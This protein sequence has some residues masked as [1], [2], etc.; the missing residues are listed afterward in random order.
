[1]AERAE[2]NRRI[3]HLEG[4]GV[5][6]VQDYL[7][8]VW[9]EAAARFR[10]L[11]ENTAAAVPAVMTAPLRLSFDVDC[12][13]DHA[14]SVWTSKIGT[15][16]PRDHTVSGDAD[17]VVLESGAGRP[18]LRADGGGDA[19]RVGRGHRVGAAPPSGLPLAHRPR[20]APRPPR[21]RSPSS[22]REATRTRIE[23][24]HTGWEA[25]GDEA[26]VWRDQNRG[27]WDALLPHFVAAVRKGAD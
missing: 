2:G 3:Y 24:E 5:R 27:G 4:G 12:A 18:D 14:F 19:A 16:W 25:L 23:I 22:A 1:M 15:W 10:L 11:A 7:E 6:A 9:G 20:A 13:P 8:G 21:W 26:E 17:E